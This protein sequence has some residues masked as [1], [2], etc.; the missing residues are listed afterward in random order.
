MN[1]PS[2]GTSSGSVRTKEPVAQRAKLERSSATCSVPVP[3]PTTGLIMS[4]RFEGRQQEQQDAGSGGSVVPGYPCSGAPEPD[5]DYNDKDHNNEPDSSSSEGDWRPL[6]REATLQGPSLEDFQ[7]GR[8]V[9]GPG[10]PAYQPAPGDGRSL[11]GDG[12]TVSPRASRL[13][14]FPRRHRPD[15]ADNDL[16]KEEELYMIL[17][18][19]NDPGI[20]PETKQYSC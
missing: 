2:T 15:P 10:V 1:T 7:K 13:A 3:R 12:L 19:I 5:N 4:L 17:I 16:Q 14:G 18:D 9:T 11:A 8:A 20:L 6:P